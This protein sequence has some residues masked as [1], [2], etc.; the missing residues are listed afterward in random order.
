MVH[1]KFG[2]TPKDIAKMDPWNATNFLLGIVGAMEKEK[3]AGGYISGVLKLLMSWLS[4]NEMSVQKKIKAKGTD[5]AT[6]LSEEST[7]HSS[8]SGELGA[9]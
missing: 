3:N 7:T 9:H 1:K 6:T 5:T 4:W 8:Q 2:K